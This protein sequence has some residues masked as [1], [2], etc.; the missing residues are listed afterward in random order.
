MSYELPPG[1][2]EQCDDEGRPFYINHNNK[3]TQ[4]E[5]PVIETPRVGLGNSL[6]AGGGSLHRN[7]S[8][9][10][11]DRTMDPRFDDSTSVISSTE[12]N[13]SKSNRGPIMSDPTKPMLSSRAPM[14]R[15]TSFFGAL[16]RPS[17]RSD[18]SE[19]DGPLTERSDRGMAAQSYFI[20]NDELQILAMEIIPPEMNEKDKASCFKCFTKFGALSVKKRCLSCGE[21]FCG[22]CTESRYPLMLQSPQYSKPVCVCDYC[23]SHLR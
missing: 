1:W 17:I 5:R 19:S 13:T 4:W 10:M 16:T 11:S 7:R 8:Q 21:I 12:S 6:S 2:E 14:N 3:T 20:D 9:M 23:Y 15:N 22:R 18:I